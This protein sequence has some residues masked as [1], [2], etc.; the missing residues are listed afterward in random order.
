MKGH[1]QDGKFHPHTEYKKG[2]RKSRD[3][4]VKSQG[5]KIRKQRLDPEEIERIT[6]TKKHISPRLILAIETLDRTLDSGGGGLKGTRYNGSMAY[7]HELKRE[8]DNVSG[9]IQEENVENEVVTAVPQDIINKT[10]RLK[11][12]STERKARDPHF[13]SEWEWNNLFEKA[14]VK[15]YNSGV[16]TVNGASVHP[17]FAKSGSIRG[18]RDKYYGN[19]ARLETAGGFIYNVSS[20]VYHKDNP[21]EMMAL[22]LDQFKDEQARK[23]LA[24]VGLIQ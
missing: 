6:Y 2:I 21:D 15:K 16:A 17:N 5:V 1:M 4:Q 18:M 7:W 20:L 11:R 24:S 8:V 3:Q 19:D 10:L 13:K 12:D 23:D 9:L 22:Q 14:T